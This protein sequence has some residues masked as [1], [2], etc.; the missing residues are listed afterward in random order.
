[1]A[2][3]LPRGLDVRNIPNRTEDEKTGSPDEVAEAVEL[4]RELLACCPDDQRPALLVIGRTA[5][6]QFALRRAMHELGL[7][8]LKCIATPCPDPW[9]VTLLGTGK[10]GVANQWTVTLPP[11]DPARGRR[12]SDR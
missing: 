8:G 2:P 11:D 9:H 10:A 4:L 6:R 12:R 3:P 5:W 7:E 1:M